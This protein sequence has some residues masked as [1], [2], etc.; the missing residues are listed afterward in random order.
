MKCAHCLNLLSWDNW[1]VLGGYIFCELSILC[2]SGLS[3]NRSINVARFSASIGTTSCRTFPGL[4]IDQDIINQSSWSGLGFHLTICFLWY[5][6]HILII[7]SSP[8]KQ[9][10][11]FSLMRIPMPY[12]PTVEVIAAASWHH[13]LCDYVSVEILLATK[14]P[15]RTYLYHGHS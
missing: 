2:R 5:W 14:F 8:V 13:D 3:R 15:Q 7:K 1:K 12:L 6:K 10:A 4:L 9:K 11:R